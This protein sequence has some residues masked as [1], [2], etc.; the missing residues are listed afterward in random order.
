LPEAIQRTK[1]PIKS[2]VLRLRCALPFLRRVPVEIR[3]GPLGGF[4]WLPS[5]GD[6]LYVE[7]EYERETQAIFL[8]M[9]AR[10]SVVYDLGAH[11]GF[12]SLL[13]AKIVGPQGRV[14]A[15]EPSSRNEHIL[16][17]QAALNGFVQIASYPF[18]IGAARGTVDFS[19]LEDDMANTLVTSSPRF[20]RS[21]SV[22]KVEARRLDDLLGGEMPAP[23]F[24][25]MDIEGAEFDALSG[26]RECLARH[27]PVLY[28]SMHEN[29]LPGVE[30]KC[31]DLLAQLD[32]D[33]AL[34]QVNELDPGIKDYLAVPRARIVTSGTKSGVGSA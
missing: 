7:G 33:V 11:R 20:A 9:I 23:Q 29:H 8:K 24:I 21:R 18:A 16:R 15:F 30:R 32:Y 10:G 5:A 12:F 6:T 3:Q 14:L 28:V 25:K 2:L 31:L 34:V 13:A 19:D 17:A 1:H 26:A 4:R 27:R 22:R